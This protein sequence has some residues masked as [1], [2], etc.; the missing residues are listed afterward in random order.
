[1]FTHYGATL[2]LQYLNPRTYSDPSVY[3]TNGIN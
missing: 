1:M 3:P 2:R